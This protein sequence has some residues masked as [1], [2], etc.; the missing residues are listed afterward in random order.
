MKYSDFRQI[1]MN[2][3]FFT[4]KD[5][6]GTIPLNSTLKLQLS[7]WANQDKIIKLKKGVYTLNEIDRQ[8][9]LSPYLL[10]KELYSPSYVSLEFALSHYQLIPEAVNIFTCITTNKTKT[11]K[12]KYGI[13]MYHSIKKEYFFGF[14]NNKS[15]D[16]HNYFLASPE[17]AILDFIYYHIPASIKDVKLEL[18][19]NYRFQ[20]LDRLNYKV[21]A[22]YTSRMKENKIN[23]SLKALKELIQEWK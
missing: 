2:K 9:S 6:S 10:A 22:E 14:K 15:P 3:P 18:S 21:L 16:N 12:N 7:Q 19:D 4:S 11:F 5:L 8:V 13:F 20:N 23:K 17:K 1:V